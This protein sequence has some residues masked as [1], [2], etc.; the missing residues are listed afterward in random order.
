MASLQTKLCILY[1]VLKVFMTGIEAQKMT[2][3]DRMKQRLQSATQILIVSLEPQSAQS[4]EFAEI[5][6]L[7]AQ[8]VYVKFCQWWKRLFLDI[9]CWNTKIIEDSDPAW[10]KLHCELKKLIRWAHHTSYKRKCQVVFDI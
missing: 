1:G 6:E 8:E 3:C 7:D 4:P 2:I 5:M 10:N 9:D